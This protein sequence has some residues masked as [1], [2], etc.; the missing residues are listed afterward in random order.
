MKR[1]VY[2]ICRRENHGGKRQGKK[3]QEPSAG[4]NSNVNIGNTGEWRGFKVI[5]SL[6]LWY[7]DV[8]VPEV[9]SFFAPKG[10]RWEMS[11]LSPERAA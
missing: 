11:V 6:D 1:I 3:R 2:F 4:R 10:Q 8:Q 9:A 5:G 7:S